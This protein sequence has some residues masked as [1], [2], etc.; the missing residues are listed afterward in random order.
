MLMS[1]YRVNNETNSTYGETLLMRTLPL[2]T[3]PDRH[4]LFDGS[5]NFK[6]LNHPILDAL[7]VSSA[8]GSADSVY[9][10]EMPI[11]HE[12]MLSWCVKT[13]HSS[14][15][16]GVYKELVA[17]VFL[18]TTKAPYPFHTVYRPLEDST[19]TDY[20]GNL[21]IYPP[22]ISRDGPGFGV[23]NDTNLDTVFIFDEVF[24]SVITVSDPTAQPFLKYR[25]S[26]VDRVMWRAF[27]FSPWIAPT[28]ITNHMER[29]ATAI[30]NVARADPGSN[31]FVAGQ[32]FAP[33]TYV[34]VNWAWLAFP[35]VMLALCLMFLVATMIKTSKG[36]NEEL[37]TWKTSAMPTLIYSLP[38]HLRQDLTNSSTWSGTTTQGAK[39]VKIRL[40]PDKGWRVS[41]Q[42]CT[43][44]TLHRRSGPR[45]PPG[46]L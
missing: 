35:L 37:G 17:D 11:A 19:D 27:R 15:S 42:I 4:T 18:N 5:I 32:A 24:P 41:G 6:N 2:I 25:T 1:G 33:E 30:T 26:F 36:A 20:Y 28:N 13:I 10:K 21:S 29:I 43:S 8:D 9:R 7:I 22:D 45:A 23:S 40:M 39:N 14:Y 38:Q 44:P 34:K 3:N 31:E 12:C 16:W 46:W